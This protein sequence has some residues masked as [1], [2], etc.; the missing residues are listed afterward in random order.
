MHTLPDEKVKRNF[1][2]PLKFAFM[3][4]LQNRFEDKLKK[5]KNRNAQ[6]R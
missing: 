4:S 1:E 6:T 2:I 3:A 5:C